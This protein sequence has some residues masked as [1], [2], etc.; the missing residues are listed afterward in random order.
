MTPTTEEQ[1]AE[2]LPCPFCGTH[3]VGEGDSESNFYQH[4]RGE[5]FFSEWEFDC[6]D[7]AAWN[8]RSPP[9]AAE[10]VE[11]L[12]DAFT[13]LQAMECPY[14]NPQNA[15]AWN[16][17]ITSAMRKIRNA[18]TTKAGKKGES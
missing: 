7:V 8:R 13:L 11:G 3:L 18:A 10:G 15:H 14:Q 12:M 6:M 17:A 16:E 1:R 4:P 2:L 5:C 9:P